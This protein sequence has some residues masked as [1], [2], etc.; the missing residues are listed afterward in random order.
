MKGSYEPKP[1]NPELGKPER[2]KPAEPAPDEQNWE[3]VPG[4]SGLQRHRIT[5]KL[6]TTAHAPYPYIPVP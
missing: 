3:A 6:R 4:R 2:L 5:G 1:Q